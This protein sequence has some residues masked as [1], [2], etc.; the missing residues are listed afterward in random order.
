MNFRHRNE[1]T[2]MCLG[3]SW[4]RMWRLAALLAALA[5]PPTLGFAADVGQSQT[6]AG[7]T[8]YIGIVPAEIVRGHP[9]AH[10]EAQA[11]GGP[12]QG[13]HEY[14]LIVAIF[15]A[16]TGTRVENAKVGARVSSLGL[17]GSRKVLEPMKIADTVT[18]GNYFDLPGRGAYTVEVEIER[19]QGTVRAK[20]DY[21]H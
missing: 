11:H 13:A 16:A 19:Q 7:L 4:A 5:W 10:P 21:G 18:Y 17:A 15:D 8:V 1:P 9:G 2:T 12:P 14:H 6:V 20:F 3:F